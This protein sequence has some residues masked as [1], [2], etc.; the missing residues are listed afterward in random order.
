MSS[1]ESALQSIEKN[2]HV[3][4]GGREDGKECDQSIESGIV[5]E[6]EGE[7]GNQKKNEKL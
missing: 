6:G 2:F 7:E 1:L 3:V 4:K 5:R